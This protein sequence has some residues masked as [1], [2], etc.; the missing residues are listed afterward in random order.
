MRTVQNPAALHTTHPC[1]PRHLNE[2]RALLL[3][4]VVGV[5]VARPTV[6]LVPEVDPLL[7]HQDHEALGIERAAVTRGPGAEGRTRE[8]GGG[9]CSAQLR[10]LQSMRDATGSDLCRKKGV[11][12]TWE[13]RLQEDTLLHTLSFHTTLLYPNGACI[14]PPP[15]AHA[16]GQSL[17]H[18]SWSSPG[19]CGSRGP[20]AA[21]PDHTLGQCGP[22]HRCQHTT[23]Q[24]HARS[25]CEEL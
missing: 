19:W 1:S 6:E 11:R 14:P 17:K 12:H 24:T 8:G 7:G 3:V 16:N 15:S 2:A 18:N 5:E 9:K 23:V 20:A 4:R 10:V 21:L 22:N 13:C 25:W